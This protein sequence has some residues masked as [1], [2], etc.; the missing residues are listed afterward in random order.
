LYERTVSGETSLEGPTSA[1][2]SPI[3]SC[4]GQSVAL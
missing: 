1:S 3:G 4:K 2:T